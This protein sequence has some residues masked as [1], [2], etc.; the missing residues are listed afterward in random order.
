MRTSP[1]E[2]LASPCRGRDRTRD[3]SP[4]LE[5]RRAT[6]AA[7][8]IISIAAEPRSASG[9]EPGAACTFSV[10]TVETASVVERDARRSAMT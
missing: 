6:C 3:R 10:R 5:F 9:I 4:R 7:Y 1:R 2:L 8:M